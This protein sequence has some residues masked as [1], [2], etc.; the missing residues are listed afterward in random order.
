MF[1]LVPLSQIP[2]ECP[3]EDDPRAVPVRSFEEICVIEPRLRDL[4]REAKSYQPRP[5]FCANEVWYRQGG[6]KERLTRLVGW[7]ADNPALRSR[8]VYDLSYDVI[9]NALPDCQHE[10]PTIYCL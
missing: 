4:Y 7:G 5:G 3:C 9:Y 8:R 6:L 2:R 1:K 10:E